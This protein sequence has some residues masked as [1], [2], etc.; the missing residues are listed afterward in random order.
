MVNTSPD[1]LGTD[2][3]VVRPFEL[4]ATLADILINYNDTKS[5]LTLLAYYTV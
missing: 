3:Q 2:L 1:Y 4:A 5:Q